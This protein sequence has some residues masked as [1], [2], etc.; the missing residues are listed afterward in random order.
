MRKDEPSL[1]LRTPSNNSQ[2][3]LASALVPRGETKFKKYFKVLTTCIEHQNQMQVCI[4]CHVLCNCSLSNIKFQCPEGNLLAWLKKEHIF[5]ESNNLGIDHP[6]TIGYFTKIVANLMHL[7]NFHDHLANQ[8]MLVDLDAELAV[9]HAPHLKQAQLDAMS[10]SNEYIP[11]LPTFEIYCT[12]LSHGCELMQVSTEVLG[13]KAMPKDAKLLGEFFMCLALAT[14]NKWHLHPKRGQLFTW[15]NHLQA[16]DEREQFFL[17][18]S[19]N[20]PSEF[21]V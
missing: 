1:V 12:H 10:S 17:D 2:I 13:I 18:H 6:V 21:G 15:T 11:I 14:N 9:N 7:A 19:G 5:L 20:D 3:V 4:G 8:L 16:N